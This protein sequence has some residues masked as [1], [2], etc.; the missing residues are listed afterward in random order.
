MLIIDVSGTADLTELLNARIDL[1][2]FAE[3]RDVDL[4]CSFEDFRTEEAVVDDEG[5]RFGIRVSLLP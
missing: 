3:A 1:A 4:S 2:R 5:G